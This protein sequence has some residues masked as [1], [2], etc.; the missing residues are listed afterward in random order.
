MIQYLPLSLITVVNPHFSNGPQ[1]DKFPVTSPPHITVMKDHRQ[2][3]TFNLSTQ[4]IIYTF[5]TRPIQY[6][7]NTSNSCVM[8]Q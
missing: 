6:Q 3:A 2:Y 8:T 5:I 4:K 1:E 7:C